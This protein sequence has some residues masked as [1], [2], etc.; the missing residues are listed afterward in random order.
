MVNVDMYGVWPSFMQLQWKH[1]KGVFRSPF[2]FFLFLLHSLD[3]REAHEQNEW[4]TE[5][6]K[7]EDP[8]AVGQPPKQPAD[9]RPE[10]DRCQQEF[11][12]QSLHSANSLRQI[13]CHRPPLGFCQSSESTCSSARTVH[14]SEIAHFQWARIL[15]SSDCLP[16]VLLQF[17]SHLALTRSV[18]VTVREPVAA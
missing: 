10:P 9:Q 11:F 17:L 4:N 3:G 7:E 13:R 6:N 1:R 2:S 5:S 15:L 8:F 16:D 12:K 18:R 14:R